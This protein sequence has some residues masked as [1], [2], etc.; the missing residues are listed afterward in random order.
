MPGA[1]T[2]RITQLLTKAGLI[3]T[4]RGID[5][6]CRL[7]K[8]PWSISLYDVLNVTDR[9]YLHSCHVLSTSDKPNNIDL[10]INDMIQEKVISTLQQV[11]LEGLRDR[12]DANI[13]LES[14][15]P[16]LIAF[17]ED[18]SPPE[19]RTFDYIRIFD[20]QIREMADTQELQEGIGL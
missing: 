8:A 4:R 13:P 3:E 18:D 1:Y 19:D 5:G 20:E 16:G 2:Q 17:Q 14:E 9:K 10:L 11:T 7:K 15:P 12:M 6:G